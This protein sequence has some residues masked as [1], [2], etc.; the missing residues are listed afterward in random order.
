[1]ETPFPLNDAAFG[2]VRTE[3]A[4]IQLILFWVWVGV[5]VCVVWVWWWCGG[6]GGG[7]EVVDS[8]AVR[9]FI[10]THIRMMSTE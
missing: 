3:I 10:P 4:L 6:G 9:L 1:M 5:G 7:G 8:V 2:P